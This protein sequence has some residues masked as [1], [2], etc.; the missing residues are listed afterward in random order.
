[1]PGAFAHLTLV[2]SAAEARVLR[3]LNFPQLATNALGKYIKYTE[4]GAVSPDL[5]YLA[6]THPKGFEWADRMH[7]AKTD[8]L[9]RAAIPRI[10]QMSGE[11]KEK[12]IDRKSKR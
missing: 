3:R 6:F 11:A 1:M 9:I 10:R 5:P 12:A 2:Q 7:Y 4:L 8:G